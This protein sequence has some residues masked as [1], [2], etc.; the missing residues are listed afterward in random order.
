MRKSLAKS[1]CY[2]LCLVLVFT[3]M[4]SKPNTVNA[5]TI[6][7]Y[8]K[9]K[10]TKDNA[11]EK[12]VKCTENGVN[13]TVTYDKL[14]NTIKYVEN[15]TE[16][17]IDLKK[18]NTENTIMTVSKD[19][20]QSVVIGGGGGYY[21]WT[22]K[23]SRYVNAD[24]TSW[25]YGYYRYY[26]TTLQQSG[27]KISKAGS[28][29]PLLYEMDAHWQWAN[30][31]NSLF[32]DHL[33]LV[34]AVGFSGSAAILTAIGIVS[35]TGIGAVVIALGFGAVVVDRAICVYK[36]K[37]ALDLLYEQYFKPKYGY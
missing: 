2:F 16:K 24:V 30:N 25:R 11:L 27:W 31:V 22:L 7:K 18:K 6:D 8:S 35:L 9:Y 13:V 1:I 23:S 5:N 10:I 19:P 32:Y 33:A 36:D 26:C 14:N 37:S 29:R 12:V 15:G 4:I 28:D 17:V 3:A 21:N 34:S 20:I